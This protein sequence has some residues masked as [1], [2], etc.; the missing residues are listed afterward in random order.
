MVVNEGFKSVYNSE[1]KS[2]GT[3]KYIGGVWV[4]E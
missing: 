4:K 2:A 3:Y 1:G